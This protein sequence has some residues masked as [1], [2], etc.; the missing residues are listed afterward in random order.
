MVYLRYSLLFPELARVRDRL[1]ADYRSLQQS[2]EQ[3]AASLSVDEASAFLTSY[4]H[5]TAQNMIYEWNQLAQY[6]IVRYNDMAV[7]RVDEE[8]RF[9][10]TPGGNQRPVLRPG[11][12]EPFKKRIVEEDGERYRMP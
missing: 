2:T 3:Q 10:Q 5:R 1:E 6:L 7:K 9:E 4:G 11:Y 8:G 12:P